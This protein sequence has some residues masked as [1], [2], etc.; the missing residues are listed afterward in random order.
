[1]PSWKP[2]ITAA[3]CA[4]AKSMRACHS[5]A[6]HSSRVTG[7]TL[8]C[9]P[10]LLGEPIVRLAS[11]AANSSKEMTRTEDCSHAFTTPAASTDVLVQDLILLKPGGHLAPSIFRRL[12]AVAWSII[13]VEAVRGFRID[14]ERRRLAGGPERRPHRLHLR[15]RNALIGLTVETEHGCLHLRCQFGRAHRPNRLLSGRIDQRAI[16]G[17]ARR[18]IGI[19]RT[20]DAYRA[21]AAAVAD[22]AEPARVAAL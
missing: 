9:M 4:A 3:Q 1:M 17:D 6:L 11:I 10:V 16:K 12:L 19:A 5:C 8:S 7:D 21:P 20:V 2:C 22:N 18:D 14:L 13:R 15:D